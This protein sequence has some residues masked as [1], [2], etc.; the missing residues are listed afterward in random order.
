MPLSWGEGRI[1]GLS[2]LRVAVSVAIATLAVPA[3]NCRRQF[4]PAA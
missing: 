4:S 1:R 2:D 3:I